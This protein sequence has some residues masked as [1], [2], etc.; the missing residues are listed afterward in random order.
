MKDKA[1]EKVKK[2]DQKAPTTP[3]L[4]INKKKVIL[5]EEKVEV[6]TNMVVKK[7]IKNKN[8]EVFI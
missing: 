1:E 8:Y 5:V 7:M 3:T 2:E 4:V 6:W